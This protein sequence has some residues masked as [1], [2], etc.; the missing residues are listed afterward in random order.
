MTTFE[1]SLRFRACS[2]K[3]NPFTGL[4]RCHS[5]VVTAHGGPAAAA[6]RS[7]EGAPEGEG[8]EGAEPVEEEEIH[9]ETALDI[10]F[11]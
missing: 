10:S 7:F 6:R 5:S 8:G 9:V 11:P 4:I 2:A 3:K 1:E